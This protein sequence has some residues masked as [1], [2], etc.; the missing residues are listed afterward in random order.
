VRHNQIWVTNADGSNAHRISDGRTEDYSPS[1]SPLPQA[2]QFLV[3][4]GV[5]G[6]MASGFVVGRQSTT[7]TSLVV[8]NAKTSDSARVDVEVTNLPEPPPVLVFTV[9]GDLLTSLAYISGGLNNPPTTVLTTSSPMATGGLVS[10]SAT[11]G[12]VTGVFPYASKTANTAQGPRHTGAPTT[13][14][15]QSQQPDGVLAY[16][17]AFLGVWDSAGQ[18]WAPGGASEGRID[19]HTGRLLSCR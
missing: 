6:A 5:V 1:W 16:R 18:N 10:F 14:S 8:F 3:A 7:L 12:T 9:S 13:Q 2:R 17:G 19:G 4:G 11:D 15:Q